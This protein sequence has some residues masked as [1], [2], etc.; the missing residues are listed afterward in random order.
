MW[1]IQTHLFQLPA[2]EREEDRQQDVWAWVNLRKIKEKRTQFQKEKKVKSQEAERCL[3]V[4]WYNQRL[5]PLRWHIYYT[6]QVHNSSW[7]CVWAVL[8]STSWGWAGRTPPGVWAGSGV[9]W[10]QTGASALVRWWPTSGHQPGLANPSTW[11][12][13]EGWLWAGNKDYLI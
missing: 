10:R 6:D 1:P 3:G 7:T 12:R 5:F 9:G 11:D 2:Q 13:G 8:T 4:L